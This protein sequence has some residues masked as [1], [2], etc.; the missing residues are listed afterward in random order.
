M[1]KLI[2][3]FGLLLLATQ[4]S[5]AGS[6]TG[7]D[8]FPFDGATFEE[9]CQSHGMGW[10][11]TGCVIDYYQSPFSQGCGKSANVLA[12]ETLRT[13]M[14]KTVSVTLNEDYKNINPNVLV[15]ILN[16]SLNYTIW[17]A[18][19]KHNAA[20]I[21]H[22]KDNINLIDI[23]KYISTESYS[24]LK[25]TFNVLD[26][27]IRV[28]Q[29]ALFAEFSNKCENNPSDLPA[30]ATISKT[31]GFIKSVQH[32]SGRNKTETFN[33]PHPSVNPA[34]SINQSQTKQ[35]LEVMAEFITDGQDIKLKISYAGKREAIC[36]EKRIP[37]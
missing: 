3:V 35:S 19:A 21:E 4:H 6:G 30:Q 33:F 12:P 18:T 28:R 15:R 9:V 16:Y 1:N 10:G 34:L 17:F 29:R 36:C 27:T 5:W 2:T 8:I 26:A 25:N 13:D 20:T 7:S 24:I 32:F 22:F 31:N 37:E 11:Y 14:Y 23:K